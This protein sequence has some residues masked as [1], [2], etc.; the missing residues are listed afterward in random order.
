MT[1]RTVA[2]NYGRKQL[3]KQYIF[4]ENEKPSRLLERMKHQRSLNKSQS[5][6]GSSKEQEFHEP[7]SDISTSSEVVTVPS[8]VQP[9]ASALQQSSLDYG[10]IDSGYVD[11]DDEVETRIE[12]E[13]EDEAAY[14]DGLVYE[15]HETHHKR[16]LEKKLATIRRQ[17][18][19][20]Y[21]RAKALDRMLNVPSSE[22]TPVKSLYEKRLES[23]LKDP[24]LSQAVM[25]KIKLLTDVIAV[26]FQESKVG[27]SWTKYLET[28][29]IPHEEYFGVIHF[30]EDGNRERK[31]RKLTAQLNE[32]IRKFETELVLAASI[33]EKEKEL[34]RKKEI[35]RR[36]EMEA[37]FNRSGVALSDY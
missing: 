16:I 27:A 5:S 24:A 12:E 2:E 21:R 31:V 26:N 4:E 28:H 32:V 22:E 34:A 17:L 20:E 30:L 9:E 23:F 33:L 19:S 35:E 18:E 25:H 8:A 13:N 14:E 37:R 15:F 7:R 29:P 36:R 3:R 11:S 1:L 6:E 10:L